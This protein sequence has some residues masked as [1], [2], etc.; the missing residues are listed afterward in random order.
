M[1]APARLHLAR[2]EAPALLGPIRAELLALERRAQGFIERLDLSPEDEA[3]V[4][5][6]HAALAN[7]RAEV[8]RLWRERGG[9]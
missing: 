7:A 3:A 5:A 8:E 1:T 6:A 2:Q 9:R 4:R